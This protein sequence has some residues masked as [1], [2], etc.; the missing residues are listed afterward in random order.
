[1]AGS[2]ESPHPAESRPVFWTLAFLG[3]AALTVAA[4]TRR[5]QDSRVA[6]GAF[7]AGFPAISGLAL[8]EPDRSDTYVVVH[9]FKAYDANDPAKPRVALLQVV[10]GTSPRYQPLALREDGLDDGPL[11]DLEAIAPIPGRPFEFLLLESGGGKRPRRLAQVEITRGVDRVAKVLGHADL[12]R[13]TPDLVDCEALLC[14]RHGDQIRVLVADRGAGPGKALRAGTFTGVVT[15]AGDAPMAVTP[16]LPSEPGPAESIQIEVT[17]E[18]TWRACSDLF[19]DAQNRVWSASAHDPDVDDG[20]F[21]T[22]VYLAG[23]LVDGRIR[24]S[25]GVIQYSL[26]GLKVEALGPSNVGQA[27]LCVAT[28]DESYG[29]A[30]RPLPQKP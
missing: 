7:P 21:R 12:A 5:S 13:Q 29:G 19:V 18:E 16:L 8:L 11:S 23:V 27:R 10:H 15:L 3:L 17:T 22:L 6:P 26:D 14:W 2:N 20:P 25:P 1:M 4:A 24:F 9:D 30:W 28:D